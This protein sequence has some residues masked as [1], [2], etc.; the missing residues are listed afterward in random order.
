MMRW[1][2]WGFLAPIFWLLGMAVIF[3]IVH[4]FLSNHG[5]CCSHSWH[6]HHQSDKAIEELKSRYAKWEITKKEYESI[7]SDLLE[8]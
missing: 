1:Y 4:F 2:Y 6:M 7:K 5:D 8:K 3:F